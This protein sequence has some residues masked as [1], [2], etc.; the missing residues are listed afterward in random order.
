MYTKSTVCVELG[1]D[2]LVIAVCIMCVFFFLLKWFLWMQAAA[3]SC[4]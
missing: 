3:G 4:W 1:T 2:D